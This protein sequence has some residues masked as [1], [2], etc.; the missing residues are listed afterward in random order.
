MLPALSAGT[1]LFTGPSIFFAINDTGFSSFLDAS[2]TFSAGK[3]VIY[4]YIPQGLNTPV[5]FRP[6]YFKGCDFCI[7]AQSEVCP[8]IISGIVTGG[9]GYLPHLGKA[10]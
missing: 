2:S 3:N 10:R 9:T 4:T 5:G 8:G 6:C 1:L 7:F